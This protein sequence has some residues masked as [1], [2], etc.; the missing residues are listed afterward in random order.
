MRVTINVLASCVLA[1]PLLLSLACQGKVESSS[2][3]NPIQKDQIQKN[4]AMPG[5][6]SKNAGPEKSTPS[7]PS[8]ATELATFGAGCFWCVEA[9]LQQ[10]EGVFK[11]TSGYMGGHV[12]NPTYEQVCTKTTGHAE[13]VQVVFDPKKVSFEELLEYFWKL[14]DPTTPN[15]QGNDEGPQY[16]SAIFYHSDSQKEAAEK[17]KKAMNSSGDFRDPIV[18]EITKAGPFYPAE[19]YHQNYYRLNKEQPYC[20]FIITPKL[21]KMGLEH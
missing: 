2:E 3:V 16:R 4:S 1:G 11:A 14:H 7:D 15:R 10:V 20:R 12:P 19:G 21:K 18:T 5:N 8:G 17:S 6:Q 9:V 13:V